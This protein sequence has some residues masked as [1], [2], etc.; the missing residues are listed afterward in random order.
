MIKG[1]VTTDSI[2]KPV[3]PF[4]T[5]VRAGGL[6]FLSGQVAQDPETGKLIDGDPGVQTERVFKNVELLLAAAGKDL[7]QVIKVAVFFTRMTDF[8]QMNEIYG[9]HFD[10]PYPARTTVAV[11]TLP[12]GAEIELD[13]VAE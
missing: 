1:I 9:R 4:S 2:A 8:Q 6:L 13:T 5:A 10:R 11:T 3:G 7:S 12:S